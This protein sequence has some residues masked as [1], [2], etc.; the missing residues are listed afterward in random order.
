MEEAVIICTHRNEKA[1]AWQARAEAERMRG[2]MSTSNI[3]SG[4]PQS[5][6]PPFGAEVPE[7]LQKHLDHLKASGISIEVLY[8]PYPRISQKEVSNAQTVTLHMR[9]MYVAKRQR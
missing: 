6:A 7:L 3:I 9:C 5:Q 8:V 1:R 2:L 4:D